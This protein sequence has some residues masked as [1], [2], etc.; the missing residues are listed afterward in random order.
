LTD[1]LEITTVFPLE[2]G[3]HDPEVLALVGA[4]SAAS[5]SPW[6]NAFPPSEKAAANGSF[7]G[8][9]AGATV[10]GSRYTLGPPEDPPAI[11]EAIQLRHRGGYLLMLSH[12]ED[13]RPL[14]LLA[15]RR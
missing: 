13:G 10:E 15:M 4:V 3:L 14:G 11:G 6:G 12:E 7:N 5:G 8:L 9:W 2:E 1:G